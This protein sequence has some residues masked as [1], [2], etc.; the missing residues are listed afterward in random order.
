MAVATETGTFWLGEG[1]DHAGEALCPSY[2]RP[3]PRATD[4]APR[5]IKEGRKCY[6]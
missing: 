1:G 5:Y 3:V 2:P 4:D 6:G